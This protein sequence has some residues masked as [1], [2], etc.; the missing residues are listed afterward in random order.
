MQGTGNL[1]LTVFRHGNSD[2]RKLPVDVIEFVEKRGLVVAGFSFGGIV[3]LDDVIFGLLKGFPVLFLRW[4]SPGCLT[5]DNAAHG[6]PA[7]T[8]VW[9][10]KCRLQHVLNVS[11]LLVRIGSLYQI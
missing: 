9:H 2:C 4:V 6:R 7:A 1:V 5:D 11:N 8:T 3:S 10:W